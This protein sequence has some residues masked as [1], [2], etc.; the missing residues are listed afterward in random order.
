[1]SESPFGVRASDVG[2]V[3][4][5][6]ALETAEGRSARFSQIE[7]VVAGIIIRAFRGERVVQLTQTGRGDALSIVGIPSALRAAL[8][9]AFQLEA[10]QARGAWFLPETVPIRARSLVFA[11]ITRDAARYAHTLAREEKGKLALS[12]NPDAMVVWSVL[13][14]L[15]EILLAP[16][17]LRVERSG[18]LSREDFGVQWDGIEQNLATLGLSLVDELAP[19]R[20]GG[21]W[22]RLQAAE[23]LV[24]KA[25]LLSA[26]AE[27]MSVDVVR[28]Y[29]AMVTRA[30]VEQYYSKAKK[31]RAKRRQVITKGHARTLAGFFGGDWLSL[32]EYLSEEPHDEERVVVALP[33]A[34]V[35]VAGTAKAAEVAAKRGIPLEEVE[36]ILGAFWSDGSANSPVLDRVTVLSEFW[37]ALD[38]IHARQAPGMLP[39]WGLVEDGGWAALAQE[40][41]TPYQAGLYRRLLPPGLV[42]RIEQ[43]WGTTVLPKWIDRVVSEPFPHSVMADTFGPALKFWHGCGL[44]AWFVCEGPMSRT[45]IPGLAEYYGRELV[46]LE[47]CRCPVHPQ[48]FDELRSVRLGP[49]M[50]VYADGSEIK[51]HGDIAIGIRMSLGSRRSGFERLRDVITRHRQWWS[52]QYLDAYLRGRWESELKS[53]AR[54]FHLMSEE[55]GKPPTLKQFSK[56]VAEPARHWFGGDV[57]LF[58]ASIGQKLPGNAVR[59]SLLMPGDRVG[60]AGAVFRALGGEPFTR[61]VAVASAEEGRQS[62]DD[63]QRHHNLLRLAEQSLAYVQL[64]EALGRTPT[65]KEFGAK[66]EWP[67]KVLDGETETAWEIFTRTVD[68]VLGRRPT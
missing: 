50:P 68:G 61:P 63:H 8:R 53:A 52:A 18:L 67:S 62:S 30:L 19:L 4:K 43:L 31:G 24:V 59:R 2:S 64:V 46:A 25:R 51:V 1:M 32:V 22:G 17:F 45:D 58:Y 37:A 39:L 48:L 34:R 20:W 44:T 35:M 29:R 15:A 16:V 14:P 36:R 13:E 28:R 41:Q 56:F 47:D 12:G 3:A 40:N 49:E 5:L 55:K 26:I 54:Q 6:L 65:L 57:G 33:E 42:T 10:Q 27:Q 66:F 38:A 7:V 60:L 23:Q 9:E 21:G 11:A